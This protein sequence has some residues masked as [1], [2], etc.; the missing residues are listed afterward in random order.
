M[1]QQMVLYESAVN[2][3]MF[4]LQQYCDSM[5]PQLEAADRYF[6]TEMTENNIYSYNGVLRAAGAMKSATL[7]AAVEGLR[8]DPTDSQ[9]T[10][11]VAKHTDLQKKIKPTTKFGDPIF[12][13]RKRRPKT[14][15]SIDDE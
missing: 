6:S 5:N 1:A 14:W 3:K 12:G 15:P 4:W 7:I 2:E 13:G 10:E 11:F 8:R 9:L